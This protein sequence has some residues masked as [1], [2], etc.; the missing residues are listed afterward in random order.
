MTGAARLSAKA[1][2]RIGAGLTTIVVPEI[3][4]PVYAAS[5]TSIMVRPLTTQDPFRKIIQDKR[6]TS[7]LIGPGAGVSETTRKDTL[8]ILKTKRPT[9]IDAD[10]LTSFQEKPSDLDGAIDGPCVLTP[11]DGEFARLFDSSDDKLTRARRAAKR[12]GAVILLK[13]PDTVIASPTGECVING[14]APATL[15]T[16]G[17]GDVLS[18]IITGLLAQGMDAFA[19]ACAATWMHGEAARLFGPGLIADDLPDLIPSVLRELNN[20][21]ARE[22]ATSGSTAKRSPVYH[23]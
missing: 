23:Q 19:A 2:A 6:F 17:S 9:V 5:L 12:S 22:F 1:A 20:E 3:A 16:A 8:T 11:H 21:K 18:G 4:F 15:A 7:F 13:G 14:N 10:A